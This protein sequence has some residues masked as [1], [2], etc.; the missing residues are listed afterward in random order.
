MQPAT[1]EATNY[2]KLFTAHS[3][4]ETSSIRNFNMFLRSFPIVSSV[5]SALYTDVPLVINTS[6]FTFHLLWKT[7]SL[8][9]TIVYVEE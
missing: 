2:Y 9:T 3:A 4:A 8:K 7:P 1:P 6:R 5:H